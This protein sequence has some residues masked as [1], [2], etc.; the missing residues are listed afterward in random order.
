MKKEV[1]LETV[2]AQAGLCSDKTT[3]AIS[4]PI[5]Q[6]ATFG[7]P[8]LGKSTGYD[9]SRTANPTRAVLEET[10]AVLEHGA[11]ASSFA[12][13]MAAIAALQCLFKPGD[14]LLVSDDLYGGTYR[15]FEKCFKPWGLEADYVDFTD[16]DK[17]RA[18]WNPKVKAVFVETPSNPMM[19]IADLRKIIKVAHEKKV[20]VI[21]D[22]TFMTPYCQQPIAMGADLVVHSGT[23]YLSGHN[24]SLSGVVV[25][26]TKALGEKIAFM[27]NSTGAVLSPFDSWLVLRG[28]KTL[29]LRMD[30]SSSNASKISQWLLKRKGVS[31]VYFPG[32]TNHPGRKI[33]FG[34]ATGPGAVL[35]FRVKSKESVKTIINRVKV[36]TYAE[37]LGGVESL[38][39]YP[40]T[41]THADIDPVTRKRLGVTDDLLRVS[42]G[43]ENCK[44]LIQDLDQAIG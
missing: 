33:H 18:G 3:G 17:V 14:R 32:L 30:R 38:V 27:Q 11:K 24:D 12:S 5:Y 20:L 22:N 36:L 10:L 39:T 8:A 26:K 15:L 21:V 2:L 43:I 31:Q 44:E 41:Q 23:K 42:V 34:Q 35:S 28:L 7:H 4:T 6:T 16:M 25:S 9:Y 1:S 40:F 19:K 13:G 29:A 37:S